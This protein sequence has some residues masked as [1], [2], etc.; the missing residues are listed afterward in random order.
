MLKENN[1]TFYQ[2]KYH[3]YEMVGWIQPHVFA[4]AV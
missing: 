2:W 4:D 1:Q 3:L